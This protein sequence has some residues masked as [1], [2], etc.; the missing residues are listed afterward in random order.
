MAAQTQTP[1]AVMAEPVEAWEQAVEGVPEVQVRT[2]GVLEEMGAA[3]AFLSGDGNYK[4][5][6]WLR[7]T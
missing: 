4:E 1:Q 3:A 5:K 6:K 7:P 2:L